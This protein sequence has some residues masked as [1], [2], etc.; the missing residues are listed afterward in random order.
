MGFG[1]SILVLGLTVRVL[2][3][4]H[5]LDRHSLLGHVSGNFFDTLYHGRVFEPEYPQTSH[6]RLN[7]GILVRARIIAYRSL[8]DSPT[9]KRY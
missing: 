5:S 2:T 4:F 1:N 6:W 3:P 8:F 9:S 7:A